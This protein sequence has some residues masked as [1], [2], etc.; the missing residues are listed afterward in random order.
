MF[1]KMKWCAVREKRIHGG[2]DFKNC[3]IEEF[4][5]AALLKI[6]QS[7]FPANFM[8]IPTSRFRKVG[9]EYKIISMCK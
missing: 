3:D 1:N 8:H 4:R 7:N 2:V 5:S 9:K 6:S